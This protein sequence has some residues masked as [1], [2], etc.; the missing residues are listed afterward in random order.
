MT[1]CISLSDALHEPFHCSE[2]IADWVKTCSS[3]SLLSIKPDVV[4]VARGIN[5]QWQNWSTLTG[6]TD[7]YMYSIYLLVNTSNSELQYSPA[8]VFSHTSTQPGTHTLYTPFLNGGA[9]AVILQVT[10]G[11]QSAWARRFMIIGHESKLLQVPTKPIVFESA[12]FHGKLKWQTSSTGVSVSWYGHFA[13]SLFVEK[14]WLLNQVKKDP[15]IPDGYDQLGGH[16]PRDGRETI[17]GVIEFQLAFQII[18]QRTARA[19][20][21]ASEWLLGSPLDQNATINTT[22]HNGDHVKVWITATDVFSNQFTDSSDLYV[23]LTTPELTE[24][25]VIVMPEPLLQDFTGKSLAD[26]RPPAVFLHL[27]I[28]DCDSGVDYF[29]WKLG[30]ENNLNHYGFQTKMV[31]N[32][33]MNQTDGCEC[34]VFGEC[35]Q[36][37]HVFQVSKQVD[38]LTAN[39]SD[40]EY[41]VL[42][43]NHAGLNETHNGTG[44]VDH[45]FEKIDWILTITSSTSVAAHWSNVVGGMTM[46][47]EV[48]DAEINVTDCKRMTEKPVHF[49]SAQVFSLKKYRLYAVQIQLLDDIGAVMTLS[50]IRINRTL[51]DCEYTFC[52]SCVPHLTFSVAAPDASPQNIHAVSINSTAVTVTWDPPPKDKHNGVLLY[53]VVYVSPINRKAT[54]LV[55]E[56]QRTITGL[57][58]FTEYN[59]R[60][61]AFTAI[62]SSPKSIA[63]KVVTKSSG[64]QK[65]LPFGYLVCVFFALLSR[66]FPASY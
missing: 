57:V 47:V 50:S 42:A 64:K 62:G 51:Q 24:L 43:V 56:Q 14:P 35:S 37:H 58:A 3:D 1:D 28:Q 16:R 15:N 11:N 21:N 13:N 8:P 39:N 7:S 20:R 31:E 25:S 6:S 19:I 22:L 48:C 54:T 36:L 40:Y 63:V 27:S 61:A 45:Q 2:P 5:I 32:I 12:V 34:T 53:Y 46:A 30:N 44:R 41:S 23:D 66:P 60:V 26:N 10:N 59:V 17:N 52:I 9:Y 18:Q 65:Q 55:P 29:E 4:N 33:Q 49:S 38:E